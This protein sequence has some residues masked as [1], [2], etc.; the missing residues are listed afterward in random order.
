MQEF[1]V[2]TKDP[3][4]KIKP[5]DQLARGDSFAP[6]Y[7]YDTIKPLSAFSEMKVCFTSKHQLSLILMP[8]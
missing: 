6:E 3:R 1:R 2:V 7:V 5:E 8:I 4:S